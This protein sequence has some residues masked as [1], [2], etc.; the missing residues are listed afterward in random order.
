MSPCFHG[1]INVDLPEAAVEWDNFFFRRFSTCLIVETTLLGLLQSVYKT[2]PI[3]NNQKIGVAISFV[4][5]CSRLRN[6]YELFRSSGSDDSWGFYYSLKMIVKAFLVII[7]WRTNHVWSDHVAVA[8][9]AMDLTWF[10][11]TLLWFVGHQGI[12]IYVERFIIKACDF[13]K[14][15]PCEGFVKKST[16]ICEVGQ[17]SIL[18][19]I[20][21]IHPISHKKISYVSVFTTWWTPMLL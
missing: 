15:V 18:T 2:T 14:R 9:A 16:S 12:M 13:W 11:N 10:L 7:A 4:L 17:Y 19:C 1:I 21:G 20:T 3:A 8:V 6:N 5:Y